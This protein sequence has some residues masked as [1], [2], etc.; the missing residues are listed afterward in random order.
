M[1]EYKQLKLIAEVLD[2]DFASSEFLGKI[3]VDIG[4][5]FE[6]PGTWFNKS[7]SLMDKDMKSATQGE[8]YLMAQW[9]PDDQKIDQTPPEDLYANEISSITEK[10]KTINTQVED[11]EKRKKKTIIANEE[12]QKKEELKTKDK[13]KEEVKKEESQVKDSNAKKELTISETK[14]KVDKSE[15]KGENES[16]LIEKNQKNQPL[17]EP[18]SKKEPPNIPGTKSGTIVVK[19][20]SGKL[21]SMHTFWKGDKI[22]KFKL[23]K[24]NPQSI[25][26]KPIANVNPTWNYEDKMKLSLPEKEFEDLTATVEAVDYDFKSNTLIGTVEINLGKTI[27][28]SPNKAVLNTY[29]LVDKKNKPVKDAVVTIELTW[30]PI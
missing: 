29:G 4:Y 16:Q 8:V 24:A 19:I 3:I 11:T 12:E 25:D 2:R 28:T 15:I 13:M 20:I 22:C 27:I 5:I 6:T 26:T 10:K 9:R 17:V 1:T 30:I 14:E 7:L 21:P 18:I 23:A